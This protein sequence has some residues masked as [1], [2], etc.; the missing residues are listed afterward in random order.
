M[1]IAQIAP[2]MESVPPR[3]YGGTERV[4]F[5]LTEE[6]VAMGHQVSLFATEDSVTT[7]ELIPCSTRAI[8]LEGPGRDYVPY[9]MLMLDKVRSRAAEFDILHFHID[10]FHF[11][12]FRDMASRTL[13]TLHGRQ[14]HRDRMPFFAGFRD[15]PLISISD[16]QRGPVP[17]ANFVAT[18]Y[19]GLPVDLLR[20]NYRPRGGYLA[21]L[22]R[23]SPEKGPV[24][25]IR[26]AQGF[27]IPLKIAAKVDPFDEVYFRDVVEP[28][29]A[30]PAVE[31]I[32]E[33]SDKEKSV[34]LGDASA[35]LFPVSWPEPFGLV[36]IEAMAC[37]TPVLAFR[38]GSVEEVIDK[39]VTG[40][41]VDNIDQAIAALPQTISLDRRK[42]RRQFEKRFPARRMASDYIRV[43][44]NLLKAD[45]RVERIVS[46]APSASVRVKSNGPDL[47][48]V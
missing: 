20:P 25:A 11:P 13:T 43:Y 33:I 24:E 47:T 7:A 1:K 8:R 2:L 41:V 39:G 10:H 46:P 21:F 15:M 48:D 26:I 23:I 14:D 22:G 34:F 45:A 19:H 3:L 5:Y 17:H 35:L 9:Y 28:L 32:G 12:L 16:V 6:L 18:V 44:R 29:L 30:P 37:G 38:A 4:V 31:Y 40:F 27:G 42:V 36:L